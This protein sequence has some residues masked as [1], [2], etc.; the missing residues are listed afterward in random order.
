MSGF[1][2]GAFDDDALLDRGDAAAV[3]LDALLASCDRAGW[4]AGGGWEEA[5]ATLQVA[6]DAYAAAGVAEERRRLLAPTAA[7]LARG[8]LAAADCARADATAAVAA[9]GRSGLAGAVALLDAARACSRAAV[10]AAAVVVDADVGDG[11]SSLLAAAKA[12][13]SGIESDASTLAAEATA[14]QA[15]EE[16]RSIAAEV[17]GLVPDAAS[18]AAQMQSPA[19]AAPTST[20]ATAAA[21]EVERLHAN[22]VARVRRA[23]DMAEK[24]L[25]PGSNGDRSDSASLSSTR[26]KTV[27]AIAA[28]TAAAD[29]ANMLA[30]CLRLSSTAAAVSSAADRAAAADALHQLRVDVIA[31]GAGWGSPC[32]WVGGETH[33]FEL[34]RRID[35]AVAI[36]SG[37][38]PVPSPPRVPE[39][40]RRRVALGPERAGLTEDCE[41]EDDGLDLEMEDRAGVDSW[42]AFEEA[43]TGQEEY[44]DEEFE[45]E[46]CL[47]CR[48]GNL[49]C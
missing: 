5:M 30:V 44:S 38:Q 33:L 34:L 49:E 29:W 3:R 48:R 37:P 35:A 4:R 32:C 41:E 18:V 28:A 12:A 1:G 21:A 24:A 7:R 20:A 16:A 9:G 10:E 11:A 17:L 6:L 23:K 19:I 45:E 39:P 8:A 42:E 36:A 47:C 22:I 46:V 31:A 43:E 14:L 26:A 25:V 13:R 2:V 15:L 40:G 27:G